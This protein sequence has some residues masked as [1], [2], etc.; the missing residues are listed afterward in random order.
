MGLGTSRAEKHLP[1]EL[2]KPCGIS[3][4][5]R[6]YSESVRHETGGQVGADREVSRAQEAP[7]TW[8]SVSWGVWKMFMH[9]ERLGI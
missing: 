2:W 4:E 3:E 9:G 5:R 7:Q 8:P 6:R 1:A